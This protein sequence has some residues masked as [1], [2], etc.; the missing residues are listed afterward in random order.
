MTRPT[1]EDKEETP[2][3]AKKKG[4]G[5]TKETKEETPANAKKKRRNRLVLKS[6]K[7]DYLPLLVP[8]GYSL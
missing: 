1:K 2:I 6:E 3:M 4:P 5:L 8:G 7:N